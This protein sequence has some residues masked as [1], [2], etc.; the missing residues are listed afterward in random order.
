MPGS[1]DGT[2]KA[3]ALLV[4]LVLATPV[5]TFLTTTVAPGMTP[6]PESDTTPDNDERTLLCAN[7]AVEIISP[8]E[9][10]DSTLVAL[11]SILD[12]LRVVS[13]LQMDTA[14]P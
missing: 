9:R 5:A 2:E 11:A 6:P 1:S 12:L 7:A 10:T 3:P 8:S 4:T 13:E 14:P